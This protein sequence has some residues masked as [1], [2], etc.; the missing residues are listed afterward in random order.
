MLFQAGAWVL[1]QERG[2]PLPIDNSEQVSQKSPRAW[3]LRVPG[4]EAELEGFRH[5]WLPRIQA[6]QQGRE[7]HDV[8]GLS[9]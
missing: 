7:A 9:V 5:V 6:G 3:C 2:S 1:P 4:S 8:P